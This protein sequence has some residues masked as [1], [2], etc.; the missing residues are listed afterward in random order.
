MTKQIYNIQNCPE[1]MRLDRYLRLQNSNF[2][3][4]FLEKASR[5]GDLK[6]NGKKTKASNRVENGDTIA[7]YIPAD[8]PKSEE[9]KL[10]H[11]GAEKL[12]YK[13]L[14]EYLIF[15]NEY[16]LVID[17]P[18]G[19]ASQ[20]GSNVTISIDDALYYLN[21]KLFDDKVDKGFRLVHR[22]DRETSG[23]FLIAKDRSSATK[24]GNGFEQKQIT[25]TYLAIVHGRPKEPSGVVANYLTKDVK[26]QIQK[27]SSCGS[28]AETGYNT[29]FF[30]NKYSLMEFEPKTGRM[31]QIRVHA[32]YL[33]C[34]IVGDEKYA[35]EHQKT[36]NLML[37]AWKLS[38]PEEIFGQDFNFES[39]MPKEFKNFKL[40]I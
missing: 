6:L 27:I 40:D 39:Q 34:P 12:A 17:K 10:P 35:Y 18:S 21:N 26:N 20:G 24:L 11:P 15:Q 23:V 13:L 32:R 7:L 29:L 37:H 9:E 14:N 31:H 1:P 33:G 28:Y 38:V 25:K 30:N 8:L 4:G 19:L 22:L 2:T 3:Q 36:T 16:F 5:K